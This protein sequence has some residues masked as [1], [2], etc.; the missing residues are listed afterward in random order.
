MSKNSYTE[1]TTN[2]KKASASIVSLGLGQQFVLSGLVGSSRAY[3]IAKTFLD[4]FL[5]AKKS[6]L[7]VLRSQDEAEA[8]A[9]DLNFF[10]GRG[11]VLFYPSS[12]LLPFERQTIHPE[13]SAKRV[14]FLHNIC[15]AGVGGQT[16]AEEEGQ[17]G[18]GP[19][20]AVTAIASLMERVVPARAL[21]K[22]IIKLELGSIYQREDLLT[23]LNEM[24]YI[25]LSM[26]EERGE[27]SL[28]GGILD[29]YPPPTADNA[30][31]PL[32]IEFFDD[33]VESIR[34]FDP[35]TQ[36]SMK[37]LLEVTILPAKEADLSREARARAREGL[38][39]RAEVAGIE[40]AEWDELY[41]ELRDGTEVRG[42][43]TILPLF[44]DG[45]ENV[46]DYLKRDSAIMLI[47]PEACRSAAEEFETEVA[48]RAGQ[49][50]L[51]IEPKELY[52]K[53]AEIAEMLTGFALVKVETTFAENTEAVA[54]VN[55]ESHTNLGLRR[56]IATQKD[57]SPLRE[58]INE[59]RQAEQTVY[60]TAHNHAQALRM[61]ELLGETPTRTIKSAQLLA[62][63]AAGKSPKGCITIA[64]GVLSTGFRCEA[65]NIIIVSEEEVFGERV[66][67][68]SPPSKKLDTFI[69]QLRDL[70]EGDYI[71]HKMHGVGIYKGLKRLVVDAIENDFLLLEYQGGDK[72]YLPVQRMDLVTR[73]NGIEGRT[74]VADRLGGKGWE[75]K[76]SKVKKAVGQLAVEL[77]KLYSEREASIGYAFPKAGPLFTEFEA[78]F[79]FD[80]TPDQ[81]QAI[82]DVIKDMQ[83]SRPMDRLV[84][85]DVGYG[86]TEV[87]MRAAFVAAL[88]GKQT[89]ILVPTTV[90]AQQHYITFKD[91]F[92]AYPVNIDML[93]RFRSRKEQN[94]TVEALKAG[95]VDI[96]IGTH[97]LLQKDISFKDLG[98][99]VIDEEQRFG[100]K[101]KERLK[102]L[103][104]NVDVLTLTATPIPRTLHMSIADIREL[105][106]INTPPEDRL[107]ITTRIIRFDIATIREAIAR[108]LRRGGQVFFVHNRVHSILEIA[109]QLR[110]I[111]ETIRVAG[112]GGSQ[113]VRIG[114]AHG[115][116]AQGEL[117]KVMLAFINR[118]YDILLSTTIIESGLDIPSANTIIINRADRFGLAELYQL[119]GRVGR[120][121]HRAY[122]Y[123]I[124]PDSSKLTADAQKRI[125]VIKELSELGSGFRIAAYDLEIRGAG[126]L[127]G[128]SQSG[129]IAEVGFE[130]YTSLLEEAVLELKGLAPVNEIEPE[131]KLNISQYI[132]DD[133]IPDTRQKIGIYKQLATAKTTSELDLLEDE[134]IDRYGKLPEVVENLLQVSGLK[135]L[136]KAIGAIELSQK[137]TRLHLSFATDQNETQ[138]LSEEAQKRRDHAI[139]RA[140]KLAKEKPKNF[141][142][143]PDSKLIY[144]AGGTS[145]TDETNN[146]KSE[147]N[148]A[149]AAKYLLKELVTQ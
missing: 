79:E 124:C 122:A 55:I 51:F 92:A 5:K 76:R 119:R 40:R 57:L 129:H 139:M 137:G 36:R 123:L 110:E 143:T 70:S 127:L 67:H 37:E 13:I 89:A 38:L 85:G 82:K 71:V 19:F 6:L 115:Q 93:S 107:A 21:E 47:D 134:L 58:A 23:S 61:Q 11:K 33:E 15:K 96:I 73:Y 113:K 60:I 50:P 26:V 100:V 35:V 1:E 146:T 121:K 28:R 41:S 83:K 39:H 98:L 68:R 63:R 20:I 132:P 2:I 75:K 118:E 114:V 87:A 142:L 106:I 74:P 42:V 7:I 136:L 8:M 69:N 49:S 34:S 91:R 144:F 81:D 145:T 54:G 80:E 117:E 133:Y 14:L 140:I 141:R 31:Y 56:D 77:I 3:F 116:M 138:P 10:L 147:K 148:P 18:E 131:L 22:K 32:R 52:I 90:L 29:I 27:I 53:E 104:K 128:S 62:A 97:R 12:E 66:K 125:D 126:E 149:T 112:K 46:L 25:R 111:V 44:Y 59:W 9:R 88:D 16:E 105:S 135:L 95:K 24:G 103:K 101:N 4:S 102:T 108:E 109:A 130:V 64:E 72:L 17:K 30:G 65:E 48:E 78:S 94:I 45:L 120:S 86:K 84:C 43:D 99:V